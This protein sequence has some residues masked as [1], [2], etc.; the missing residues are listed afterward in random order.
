MSLPRFISSLYI[1]FL[2]STDSL[3]PSEFRWSP[4]EQ[5][6][7]V[8]YSPAM[9][10]LTLDIWTG[11]LISV[12]LLG[13]SIQYLIFILHFLVLGCPIRIHV[14]LSLWQHVKYL[15]LL[16][17]KFESQKQR[18]SHYANGTQPHE[19]PC[20]WWSQHGTIYRK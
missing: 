9:L 17:G 2:V 7:E 3:H 12:A 15:F 5:N 18:V 6:F 10:Y 14:D 11:N 4:Q 16:W 20:N 1:K 13:A 19:S 8:Y